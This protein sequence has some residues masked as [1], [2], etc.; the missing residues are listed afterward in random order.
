MA[1]RKAAAKRTRKTPS[2]RELIDTGKDKR[3]VRRSAKGQFKESDDVGRSA[4][5]GSSAEGQADGEE[6]PGGPGATGKVFVLLSNRLGSAERRHPYSCCAVGP[7]RTSSP[8]SCASNEPQ[9]DY[10]PEPAHRSVNALTSGQR[11]F[12]IIRVH[13][14]ISATER[15]GHFAS[16]ATQDGAR[17]YILRWED[18]GSE[19]AD[20]ED[21]TAATFPRPSSGPPSN[22]WR[23]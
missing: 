5:A 12:P 16:E 23:S 14:S 3:Y 4:E 22:S 17:E 20:G 2:K 11:V 21:R 10:T 9:R 1:K 6:R 8:L 13:N 7:Q 19:T 15:Q 18:S